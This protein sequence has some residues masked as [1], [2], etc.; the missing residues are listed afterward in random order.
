MKKQI[1]ISVYSGRIRYI[2]ER[3]LGISG[4]KFGNLLG[5]SQDTVS[6]WERGIRR[7]KG[8]ALIKVADLGNCSVDW[9]LTGKGNAPGGYPDE[10]FGKLDAKSL[11]ERMVY[12]REK[13][14]KL[15]RK[16]LGIRL[17]ISEARISDY[18]RGE[19]VPPLSILKCFAEISGVSLSFV[20]YG[21]SEEEGAVFPG[22]SGITELEKRVQALEGLVEQMLRTGKE[23]A[24][25]EILTSNPVQV[26]PKIPVLASLPVIYPVKTTPANVIDWLQT[27]D[28]AS[29]DMENDLFGIRIEDESMAPELVSDDYA[30]VVPQRRA[31]NHEIIVCTVKGKAMI[32][33][34]ESSEGNT[35]LRPSNPEYPSITLAPEDDFQV[36]GRVYAIGF[37][38]L[39]HYTKPLSK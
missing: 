11:G 12:L 38:K 6:T 22:K 32:R 27:P 31:G 24:G 26:R 19:L 15:S 7:P 20:A 1:D 10:I 21:T 35:T 18:E 33:L 28:N 30:L 29:I 8:N 9:I 23:P 16:E 17:D 5:I 39:R 14:L 4:E 34:F 2:R 3:I 13:G 37:R 36:I 25:T